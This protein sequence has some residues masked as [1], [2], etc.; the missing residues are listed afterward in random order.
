MSPK[1]ANKCAIATISLGKHPLHTLERKIQAARDNGF[2]GIELVHADLVAHA[3]QN[4]QTTLESA[5]Q[6]RALCATQS[7]EILTLNPLKNFEGN[8]Q[9]SLEDRLAEAKQWIKLAVAAGTAIIQIPS[10]FLGNSN[11][12]ETVVIPE[13]QTL[14]DLAAKDRISLAYEAVSFA[15]YNCLWQDSLRIVVA[16]NRPNFGLCIDSFH[17]HSRIW[18]D[19]TTKSGILPG[20]A[21]ALAASMKE[22]VEQCPKEKVLYVQL[23][24]ASRFDPPLDDNSPYYDGLEVKDPRLAWSRSCR[25]FPLE[26]YFPVIDMA[27]AIAEW[28]WTG[29]ISIECFLQETELEE[30]GPEDMA[31]RAQKSLQSLYNKL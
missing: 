6:I 9:K 3:A 23:S 30:N 5:R 22:F 25:P 8:L 4:T 10:Q 26:G 31:R 27:K 17:I 11:G 7:L 13:L 2:Q 21:E 19:A 12:D 18:G 20:G 14:A 28:G 24:D 16:V 1:L 29:W 15:T